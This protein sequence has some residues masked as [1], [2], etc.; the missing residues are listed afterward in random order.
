M[1]PKFM[2]TT[3]KKRRAA[4]FKNYIV[5]QPPNTMFKYCQDTI[6][7]VEVLFKAARAR[8]YESKKLFNKH[9]K[10]TKSFLP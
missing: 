8:F 9:L 1:H 7:I 10:P 4:E 6:E 2:I 3:K 5:H